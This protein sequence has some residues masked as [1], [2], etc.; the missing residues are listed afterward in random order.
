MC[1]YCGG[2]FWSGPVGQEQIKHH[3]LWC[4]LATGDERGSFVQHGQHIAAV[5][6]DDD[7]PPMQPANVQ[8][9]R[10][11]PEVRAKLKLIINE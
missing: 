10:M 7:C 2:P 8:A 3:Y 5:D 6:D 4:H 1:S 9:V 11:P